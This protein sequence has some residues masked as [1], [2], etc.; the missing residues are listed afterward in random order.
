MPRRRAE[1]V[2]VAKFI[3]ILAV[4]VDHTNGILYCNPHVALAS[5]FS[6]SL[7]IVVMG[8]TL[9]WSYSRRGADV[10][11]AKRCW[12]IFRPYSIATFIYCLF[13]Y[14]A[15]DFEVYLKH[16]VGF[17][18][19]GPF[20]Y[21]LLYLQLLLIPPY[22]FR[23]CRFDRC[24]AVIT[25][26]ATFVGVLALSSFTT[27]HTNILNVYGGGGRLFGGTYLVLLYVG[28][29][30]GKYSPRIRSGKWPSTFCSL[31]FLGCTI[32]WEQSVVVRHI[33]VD[34]HFPFGGGFNPPSVSLGIYA[35]LIAFTLM[36][37]GKAVEQSW[38]GFVRLPFSFLA[39]FG[40]HTLHVFLYHRLFLDYLLMG[41]LAFCNVHR[42]PAVLIGLF[43]FAAMTG[44]SIGLEYLLGWLKSFFQPS[45]N[46]RPSH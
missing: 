33:Q 20:Y 15:F 4:M 6:V 19:S 9:F 46:E 30:I 23:M 44:G 27:N 35:I 2:D 43:F 22:L 18:A 41:F 5:Y 1:W 28:M 29:L 45:A 17:S 42:I 31:V 12:T 3:A 24:K 26:T 21:V 32:A 11:L 14:K 7:F 13:S 25:E 34:A 16:L 10:G 37:A 36:F 40:R 39:W 38:V 8:V